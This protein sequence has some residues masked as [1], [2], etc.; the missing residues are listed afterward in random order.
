MEYSIYVK[1]EIFITETIK[2]LNLSINEEKTYLKDLI[3]YLYIS[4]IV[5][6]L[7]IFSM[8]LSEYTEV[9]YSFY[10]TL[11]MIMIAN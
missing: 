4:L 11:D 9:K 5:Y 1:S 8:Y 3:Q 7:S 2:L 6:V 10:K